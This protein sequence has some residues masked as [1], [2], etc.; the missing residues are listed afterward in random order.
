MT[1]YVKVSSDDV[2]DD[3]DYDGYDDNDDD[4]DSLNK[5][6]L[7]VTASCPSNWETT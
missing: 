2:Y 3:D 6:S 5:K 1:D 4:D 7:N